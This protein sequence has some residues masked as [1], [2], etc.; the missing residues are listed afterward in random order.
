MVQRPW[1]WSI[2]AQWALVLEELFNT[3]LQSR[4]S[5]FTSVKALIATEVMRV[6]NQLTQCLLIC[7]T[8]FTWGSSLFTESAVTEQYAGVNFTASGQVK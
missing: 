2:A 7:F 4:A 8:A 5:T 1:V 6:S 3:I